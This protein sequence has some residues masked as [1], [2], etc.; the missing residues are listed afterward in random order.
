MQVLD[1]KGILFGISILFFFK[2]RCLQSV[3]LDGF[4]V[5]TQFAGWPNMPHSSP[6]FVENRY[7]T[8]I[9][10]QAIYSTFSDKAI[11]HATIYR[12]FKKH[13]ANRSKGCGWVGG[14]RRSRPLLEVPWLR[15]ATANEQVWHFLEFLW[16]LQKIVPTL[17]RWKF[18]G[19]Y[20][21]KTT[22][23]SSRKT[24]FLLWIL[25]LSSVL[26]ST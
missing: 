23:L 7:S 15:V 17:R 8:L 18:A 9:T 24:V 2:L 11:S 4:Q 16:L 1:T 6:S 13:Q 22:L 21:C 26:M 25:T 20:S 12:W 14:D 5:I 10:F 19:L 3:E